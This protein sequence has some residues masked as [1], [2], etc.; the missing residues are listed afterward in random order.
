[1]NVYEFVEKLKELYPDSLACEWDNDGLMSSPGGAREVSR[2]LVALDATE[3]AVNYAAENGFDTLLV[4]HP[5]IFSKL[6]SVTPEENTARKVIFTLMNDISVISLHT[7]LDA[8]E[9]G[10]NDCLAAALGLRD[11]EK[12]GDCECHGMGRI[13]DLA[14]EMTAERFA[15]YV[16][17]RLGASSVTL[18]AAGDEIV[19]R[20]A[21]L[22]GSGKDFIYPAKKAGAD[23]FVTGEASYNALIDAAENGIPVVA[24]GHYQTEFVV[25]ER[26]AELATKIAD[27][28]CEIY[29]FTPVK[30][31]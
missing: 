30:T 19:C 22:G 11:I 2:V 12:F 8:G 13:G 20:V 24:A 23:V 6:G 5:L 25:C 16:K 27:A 4:H 14:S 21:V 9:G 18:A 26:L 3:Q 29:P 28:E 15:E 17:E 10:V 31:V 1:M 7:R